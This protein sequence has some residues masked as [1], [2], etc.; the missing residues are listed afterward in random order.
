MENVRESASKEFGPLPLPYYQEDLD[1]LVHLRWLSFDP[2][3]I[4]DIGASN[5]IWSALASCIYPQARFELF[6]PLNKFSE[7]YKTSKKSHPGIQ[8]F[9]QTSPHAI[10]ELALGSRNGEC[11]FTRYSHDVGS[12][13]LA[14]DPNTPETTQITVPI[15]RLDDYVRLKGLAKPDLMKLDTQG[16]EMEIFDGA[17]KCLMA[18]QV[19]FVE[20]WLTK[21]YGSNTPLML[22]MANFLKPYGFELFSIWDEYRAPQTTLHAVDAVFVK[23]DLHLKPQPPKTSPE[24]I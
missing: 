23:K 5:S 6:E 20:T 12:T 3:T 19:I 24:R 1:H 13:S 10:H 17:D 4:Y 9:H 8:R 21:G 7:N 2:R 11:V 16:S 15:A 22:E 14:V 18:C